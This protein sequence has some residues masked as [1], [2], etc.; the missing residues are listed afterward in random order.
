[1]TFKLSTGVT[2]VTLISPHHPQYLPPR[3]PPGVTRAGGHGGA[4]DGGQP[5]PGWPDYETD[6]QPAESQSVLGE[7]SLSLCLGHLLV[8]ILA[9]PTTRPHC[10][11]PRLGHSGETQVRLR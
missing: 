10:P 11:P 6:P 4:G 3:P 5:G 8:M 9:R 2:R 7:V 1:M